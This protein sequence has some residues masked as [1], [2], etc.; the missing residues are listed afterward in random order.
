MKVVDEGVRRRQPQG[1]VEVQAMK[2]S[3]LNASAVLHI[4]CNDSIKLITNT[5]CMIIKQL[6]LFD[7]GAHIQQLHNTYG[8]EDLWVFELGRA[9]YGKRGCCVV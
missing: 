8:L 4:R 9:L 2:R 7:S 6:Y 5:T 3:I 1:R